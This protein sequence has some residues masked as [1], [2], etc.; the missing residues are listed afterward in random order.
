MPFLLMSEN[1]IK[2]DGFTIFMDL[3][4]VG[5]DVSHELVKDASSSNSAN[6]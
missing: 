5:K 4:L 1:V 2:P 6:I 3:M